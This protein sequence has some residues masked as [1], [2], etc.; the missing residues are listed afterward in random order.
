MNADARLKI[1]TE[2]RSNLTHRLNH[3]E[4]HVG[5]RD[6]MIGLFFRE[7]PGDHIGVADG[8]YLFKPQPLR[9]GVER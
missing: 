3:A 7:S 5:Y 8:F 9:Q 1:L 6:G 2:L 4:R